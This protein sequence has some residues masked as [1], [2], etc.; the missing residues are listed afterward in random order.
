MATLPRL[1]PP[2]K[3]AR[4]A[5]HGVVANVAFEIWSRGAWVEA[6]HAQQ[7]CKSRTR[8][9]SF[10]CE[11]SS[12]CQAADDIGVTADMAETGVR[13]LDPQIFGLLHVTIS[14]FLMASLVRDSLEVGTAARRPARSQATE[15]VDLRDCA[16]SGGA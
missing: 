8:Y 13:V 10:G 4:P 12:V 3:L 15:T 16:R 14:D 11:T 6:P 2:G 1:I 9:N 5:L 7:S